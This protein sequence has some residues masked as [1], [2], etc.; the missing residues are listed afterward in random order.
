VTLQ[1][2]APASIEAS[3]PRS[4]QPLRWA[5]AGLTLLGLAVAALLN[6]STGAEG[7]IA[8]YQSVGDHASG[9]RLR[10]NEPLWGV[11]HWTLWIQLL[12]VAGSTIVI[13]T[14]AVLSW[15]RR[16]LHPAVP[17]VIALFGVSLLDPFANWCSSAAMNPQ[18]LHYPVDWPYANISPTVQPLVNNLVYPYLFLFP[19]LFVVAMWKRRLH[20]DPDATSW[21]RR[22][23]RCAVFGVSFFISLP[24]NLVLVD[25]FM[26]RV[27]YWTYTQIPG[28]AAVRAGSSWQYPWT[29]PLTL[30]V[31]TGATA[32]F[33]WR[34]ADGRS[35]ANQIADRVR[36]LRGRRILGEVLVAWFF[37]SLSYM[38]YN[39]L[40]AS[41]R[42]TDSA[43]Q[44]AQPWPYQDTKVYDPKGD[45]RSAGVPGPYYAGIW[46]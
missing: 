19:A 35:L 12:S 16:A 43:D 26:V 9:D 34:D 28:W 2:A 32:V 6:A 23:P 33:L 4:S 18:L 3:A 15:R 46:P 1:E 45:Y 39:G 7:R 24:V 5:A 41:F 25:M 42:L 17:V 27:E 20:R 14:F 37:L 8:K 38:A 44:V 29:D 10:A 21:L 11:E 22:H 13:T 36:P 31:V 30:S 40:W